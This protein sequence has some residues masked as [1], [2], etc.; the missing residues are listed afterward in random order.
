MTQGNSDGLLG[1]KSLPILEDHQELTLPSRCKE[2][3]YNLGV[4]GNHLATL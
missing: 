3:Y 4:I 1:K 2:E